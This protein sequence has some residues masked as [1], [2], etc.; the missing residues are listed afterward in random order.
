MPTLTRPSRWRRL[1]K[2]PGTYRFYRADGIS[3]ARAAYWAWLNV[4]W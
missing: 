2:A 4:W 1:W 3:A